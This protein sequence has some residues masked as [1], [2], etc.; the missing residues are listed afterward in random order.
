MRSAL[1]AL[2]VVG[3][4]VA[5]TTSPV[6]QADG[7]AHGTLA[8]DG[9]SVEYARYV[10]TGGAGPFPMLLLLHGMGGNGPDM[11]ASWR[12]I[13]DAE[14]IVLVAPTL[15]LTPT[16]ESRVPVLIPALLDA[17]TASVNV[18]PKRIY[19]FGYSAGGFFAFNIATVLS[20]R[21]AAVAVFASIISHDYEDNVPA[22]RRKT[23]IAYYVGD[24][25]EFFALEE[26]RRT[27][28][29]LLKNG[30]PVHYIEIAGRDH[31]YPPVAA[32]VDRDAWQ[33]L[34]AATLP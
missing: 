9:Y 10:P 11:L 20:T 25:D 1:L 22:A 21:F 29:L 15:T 32:Q 6:M 12:K 3:C 19:A 28:D 27:R 14:G 2:A 16:Q 34:R 17:A 8:F 23:P 33:F 4:S 5:H 7:T 30:F 24:R 31:E 26:T 18:D 13:A